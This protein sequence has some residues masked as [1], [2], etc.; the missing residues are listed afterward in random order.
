MP[1][2]A[3]HLHFEGQKKI[4]HA[5]D[6][7]EDGLLSQISQ[8]PCGIGSRR[9]QE[10]RVIKGDVIVAKGRSDRPGKRALA[11][12]AGTMHQ[13]HGGVLQSLDQAAGG[14]PGMECSFNHAAD[15]NQMLRLV[16]TK[17]FG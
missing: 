7:I 17:V 3:I 8:E 10:G 15:C 12:L 13:H 9:L 5:L 16:V 1:A 11:T 4:R 2:V 14:E 6:L